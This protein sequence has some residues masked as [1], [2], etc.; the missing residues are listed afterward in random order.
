MF[1]ESKVLPGEEF[2]P[3]GGP[4]CGPVGQTGPSGGAEG[5]QTRFV[6]AGTCVMYDRHEQRRVMEAD[7]C[8]LYGK[9]NGFKHAA[10]YWD[11]QD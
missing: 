8:V 11:P 5:L 6:E 10:N 1:Y 2:E 4:L 9:H 3:P 7:T